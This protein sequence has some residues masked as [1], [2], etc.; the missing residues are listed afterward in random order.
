M[1]KKA[2]QE[3]LNAK[4]D[5]K[6]QERNDRLKQAEF[7]YLERREKQIARIAAGKQEKEIKKQQYLK[8]KAAERAAKLKLKYE[9]LEQWERLEDQ[10]EQANLLKEHSRNQLMLEHI[11]HL[12]GKQQQEQAEAASRKQVALE[13]RRRR[14]ATEAAELAEQ[15]KLKSELEQKRNRNI[16]KKEALREQKNLQYCDYIRDLKTSE[17]LNIEEQKRVVEEAR[18][19][20]RVNKKEEHR[21]KSEEEDARN[22]ISQV[23]EENIRQR[24]KERDKKFAQEVHAIKQ[25]EKEGQLHLQ[26]KKEQRLQEEKEAA[27]RAQ[28]DEQH[29]KQ[30]RAVLEEQRETAIRERTQE[31]NKREQ[32]RKERL[33]RQGHADGGGIDDQF[34]Q[35][36]A[37]EA[38]KTAAEEKPAEDIKEEI[39]LQD[40]E[41]DV[42]PEDVP[43]APAASG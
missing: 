38:L 22:A 32:D 25:K 16:A 21:L 12:R 34:D 4:R 27:E 26:A 15:T 33:Q 3:K 30:Q 10:R 7:E 36:P 43:E 29:R 20:Q 13:E 5:E 11:D 17:A 19:R 35:E 18:E 40:A 39:K 23:R 24:E 6:I 31:R 2:E 1:T 41:R 28:E 9:K 8:Q 37:V 14:E 42:L